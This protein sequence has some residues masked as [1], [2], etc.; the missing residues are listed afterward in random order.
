MPIDN[1]QPFDSLK[2]DVKT[3]ADASDSAAFADALA[4]AIDTYAMAIVDQLVTEI[5]A[6]REEIA[7]AGVPEHE[8]PEYAAGGG[9]APAE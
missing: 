9:E 2:T 6:L 3:A 7:A 5:D 1:T 8:H 4:T